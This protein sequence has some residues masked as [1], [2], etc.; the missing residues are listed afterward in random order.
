MNTID[1][2]ATNIL[3]RIYEND[4][5]NGRQAYE[6]PSLQKLVS[7]DP[8][9]INDAV[10]FLEERDLISRLNWKGTRPFNFGQIEMNSRG[11]QIYQEIPRC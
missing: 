10:D 3:V 11:R 6:G 9:D 7:L 4:K 1:N 2:N 5:K 8:E